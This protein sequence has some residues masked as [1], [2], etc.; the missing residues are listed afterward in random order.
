MGRTWARHVWLENVYN[1]KRQI[2][3]TVAC[4]TNS[5]LVIWCYS[6]NASIVSVPDDC[7]SRN[8]SIVSVPDECYSRNASIVSVPNEC[9]S[10]NASIVS[11]PDECYSRNVSI[12]SVPDECYSRN[13]SIVSVYIFPWARLELTT[14]VIKGTD[15]IGSCKSNYHT[16]TTTTVPWLN[17]IWKNVKYKPILVVFIFIV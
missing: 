12:V 17:V 3:T 14:L 15:C 16:N 5:L 10:R 4:V 13:V 9:Y 7:Y 2:A 1:R 11:V 6:R 8:A